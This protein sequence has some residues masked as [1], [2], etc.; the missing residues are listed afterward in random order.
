M[1]RGC[2]SIL[3]PTQSVAITL[4]A[5]L[6]PTVALAQPASPAGVVT[7]LQG[8][9]T[10]AR[11]VVPQPIPLKFKDDLFLRD[12]VATEE[13]SVVRVLLGGKAL[14][15]VR[16]LSTFKISEQPGR[17]AVDLSGGKIAVG[18]AKRDRKSTRLNSSHMS[19]SYAVFC[20]KKKKLNQ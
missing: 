17:A 19:I 5:V 11:P 13:K 14:V 8:R 4:L 16:E 12:Q 10:V 9:A 1:R 20:L 15:T 7:G 3:R 6:W 18:V 2:M